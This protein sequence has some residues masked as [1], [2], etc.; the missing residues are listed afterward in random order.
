MVLE[1]LY[2]FFYEFILAMLI[3]KNNITNKKVYFTKICCVS[4]INYLVTFL[5]GYSLDMHLTY[6]IPFVNI[7]LATLLIL[8]EGWIYS[9][10]K[11]M[12]YDLFYVTSFYCIYGFASLCVREIMIRVFSVASHHLY[13]QTIFRFSSILMMLFLTYLIVSQIDNYLGRHELLI[14]H[15]YMK[16]FFGFMMVIISIVILLSNLIVYEPMIHVYMILFLVIITFIMCFIVFINLNEVYAEKEYEKF[17]NELS[18]LLIQNMN[19]EMK[20]NQDLKRFKHDIKNK[21]LALDY[22]DNEQGHQ[23]YEDIKNEFNQFDNVINTGNVYIDAII[24]SKYTDYK[25]KIDFQWNVNACQ[26]NKMNANDLCSILYNVLDNAVEETLRIHQ[27]NIKVFIKLTEDE[28]IV[29]VINLTDKTKEMNYL[30]TQKNQNEHGQG[31]YILEKTVE[32][33]NGVYKVDIQDN[34]F[35]TYIYISFD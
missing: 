22:L 24:N 14:P 4:L 18:S 32:K 31:L 19:K 10:K 13:L 16:I 21:L 28:F 20:I 26:S 30:E 23:L 35:K 25:D 1:F 11:N 34:T 33:Y 6:D 12:V 29:S 15:K 27:S 3:N 8:I 7:L 5:I 9:N 17:Q 2:C